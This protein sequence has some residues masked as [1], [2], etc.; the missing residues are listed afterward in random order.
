M[1]TWNTGWQIAFPSQTMDEMLLAL[2]V[3]DLIHGASY[4][5]EAEDSETEFAIDYTAGDELENEGYQLLL[6]AEIEGTE[7][8]ELIHSFTEQMLEELLDEAEALVR[9]QTEIGAYASTEL[10]FETVPEDEERWDL[11]V[12]DWLA[13]DG[14]EVPFGFRCFDVS[15][16]APVPDNAILDAHGRVIVVPTGDTIHLIGIPAPL[17]AEPPDRDE[18]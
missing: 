16:G 9:Q 1:T 2:V 17:G 8:A 10:R 3:R 18:T 11:V 4:D 12:P 5:V 15:S 7:N 14:A 6:A 13:P